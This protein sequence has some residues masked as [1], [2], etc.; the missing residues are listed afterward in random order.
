MKIKIEFEISDAA[1]ELLKRLKKEGS[2]EYRDPEYKSLDNYRRYKTLT[3]I[4]PDNSDDERF[5]KRNSDGTLHLMEELLE[6]NLVDFD[7]GSCHQTF[8]LSDL[9]KKVL[10][11]NT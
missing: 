11:I 4:T 5:L 1:F 10:Q 7:F 6:H 8:I 2:L 9:G 3:G